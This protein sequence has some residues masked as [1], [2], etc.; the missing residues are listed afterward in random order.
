MAQEERSGILGISLIEDQLRIVE[1]KRSNNEFQITHVSQGRVRQPLNFEVFSDKNIARRFAEDINRLYELQEFENKNAAFS[2]DSKMVM[3]KKIPVD[4]NLDGKDLEEQINWEVRQFIISPIE[5]YIVDYEYL[6][7]STHENLVDMLIVVVRKKI[8][9]F[10]KSVF[11]Q[12]KLKLKSID[13]DIFSAQRALQINYDYGNS[14]RIGLI[15]VEERNIHILI[16]EGK[17]YFIS[18]DL[19]LPVN[20]RNLESEETSVSRLIS[21][22]LR[23]IILDHQLGR[24]VEDLDEIFLYGEALED[25][26]LEDLQ[27]THDVRIDRANPFKRIKLVA[28]AKEGT[29]RLQNERFMISVGAALKEL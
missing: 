15:D 13:V 19:A 29:S 11:K 8:I 3:I 14:D 23:K 1:S 7:S 9:D 16:L 21:K 24:S 26:L 12:T 10:L 27:N 20:N 25:R 17:N 5:E 28:Q 2:L 6:S 4:K 18:Q 22:E